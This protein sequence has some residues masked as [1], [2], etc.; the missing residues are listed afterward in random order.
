[1]EF[2]QVYFLWHITMATVF[3]M[4]LYTVVIGIKSKLK[5]FYCY[6][7]YSCFM[8][9]YVS[10]NLPYFNIEENLS[11]FLNILYINTRWFVQVI[12]NTTYVFFFI[13]LLEVKKHLPQFERR[14]RKSVIIIFLLSIIV[15]LISLILK[16][17]IIFVKYF[18][19][20]FTPLMSFIGI[21]VLIKLWEIQGKLKI[22][23]FIGGLSYMV[24]ALIALV[25]S[26]IDN[27]YSSDL[28]YPIS[29]FY[30]GVIIEQIFFGFALAYFIQNINKK[31]NNAL[32]NNLKLKNRH[33]RELNQKLTEQSAKLRQMAEEA[34]EK[35]VTLVKSEYE[36]KLNESRLSSLQS[37]MNP[38][39]IFNALNS[40]KAYLIENDKRKAINYM[41]RF[42]KLV[43]K[44]L[45]SSRI[46]KVSLEEELE[47]IKLYVEIENTRFN[48]SIHFN[49]ENTSYEK[50][51]V[52]LPP[53]ILQPFVENALWHGLAPSGK[54]KKLSLKVLHNNE[55]TIV[56][57]EDNGIGRTK[58]LS[59]YQQNKIKRKSMGMK[60]TQE[61]F[62]IF[63]QK[64][65][66]NYYFEII[67][68][69]GKETGTIVKVY[70]K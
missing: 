27:S 18:H 60:M 39:F 51:N 25:M 55:H 34:R 48:N 46:E 24:L 3:L 53:L 17:E 41:N 2:N 37:K 68:K 69:S 30:I 15:N 40:I 10:F 11:N 45:E 29:Y 63:N 52:F 28:L 13:Y 14:L 4:S 32:E 26:I 19:Y 66:T 57:I 70:L 64:F 22:Y 36:A 12:Y 61:R 7:I 35:K 31:Y 20:A 16:N 58:S 47:I 59:D 1:M 43:R 5:V 67:E 33:N 8:M 38:H 42:S 9:I 65:G 21:I 6:A 54:E 62:E 44:I 49:I 56:E 23:F 50:K